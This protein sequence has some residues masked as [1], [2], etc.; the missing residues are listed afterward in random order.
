MCSQKQRW[1]P[2]AR[3]RLKPREPE[4]DKGGLST[5]AFGG[6]LTLLTPGLQ[7]SG[8]QN[9]NVTHICCVKPPSLW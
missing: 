5:R 2:G 1:E 3:E 6:S 9:G 4:G 7:T 8:L